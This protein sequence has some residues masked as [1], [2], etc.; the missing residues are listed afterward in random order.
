MSIKINLN[1]N[2]KTDVK[3]NINIGHQEKFRHPKHNRT[4]SKFECK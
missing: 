3:E 2:F 1:G 4:D